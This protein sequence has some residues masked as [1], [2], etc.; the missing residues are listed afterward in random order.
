[1]KGTDEKTAIL[2]DQAVDLMFEIYL[3]RGDCSLAARQLVK[4]GYVED[5][6]LEDCA[7]LDDTL[8]R[9]YRILQSMVRTIQRSRARRAKRVEQ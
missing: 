5:G 3:M 7:R 2:L 1:V 9:T 6:Q 4:S 8:A